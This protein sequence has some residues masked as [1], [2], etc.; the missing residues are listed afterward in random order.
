MRASKERLRLRVLA[1]ATLASL[2]VFVA[3]GFAASDRWASFDH[4][5][6]TG[7]GQAAMQ[8]VTLPA[9]P[10]RVVA[11]PG[12][13]SGEVWAIGHS[14]AVNPAWDR[15]SPGGQVIFL[16]YLRSTGWRSMGPP[17]DRNNNFTNPTLYSFDIAPSGEGWAVGANAAMFHKAPGSTRWVENTSAQAV[18]GDGGS[19]PAQLDSVSLVD[20]NGLKGFAVGTTGGNGPNRGTTILHLDSGRWTRESPSADMVVD[21]VPELISVSMVSASEAWAISG[22]GSAD[23]RVYHLQGTAWSRVDPDSN[24]QY[25]V[26]GGPHTPFAQMS[27]GG[28]NAAAFGG[29]VKADHNG[30]W[31]GGQMFPSS[32]RNPQGDDTAGDRSRPFMLHFTP[33]EQV[34]SYCPDQYGADLQQDSVNST[35]ICERPFPLSLYDVTSIS[36]LPNGEAFA[37]GLGLYHFKDEG[38]FREPD[39]EGY[40]VSITFS[41]P[42]EGWVATTGNTFGAGGAVGSSENTLGHWTNQPT[43]PRV[44]EWPQPQDQPLQS[45]A[46]QPDGSGRA[47]AV[48]EIGTTM[49]YLPNVGWDTQSRTSLESLHCVA[50]AG[51]A[52]AWAV[53]DRGTLQIFKDGQWSA[54]PESENLTTVPLF[55]VAFAGP[56][57]GVAVGSNG[58][59]LRFNGTRWSRDPASSKVTTQRLLAVAANAGTMIAVGSR[60]AVI[61]RV[62]GTWRKLSSASAIL[63]NPRLGP[64][65]LNTVTILPDGTALIAGTRS[66]LIIRQP[67]RAFKVFDDQIQ[68]NILAI[69]GVRTHLGLRLFASV[70]PDSESDAAKYKGTRMFAT[71]SVLMSYDGQVWNDI[72]LSRARTTYISTDSSAYVD[73]MYGLSL[74]AD[75]SGWAVGGLAESQPDTEHPGKLS[76]TSSVY[77]FDLSSSPEPPFSKARVSIPARGVNLAFVA[78]TWCERGICSM[79]NGSGTQAEVVSR[80]I[81]DQV[82]EVAQLRNGP[83]FLLFGGNGRSIGIPEEVGQIKAYLNGFSI[84]AY[85]AVGDRDLSGG[86][87]DASTNDL[88]T[89]TESVTGAANQVSGGTVDK[90]PLGPGTGAW[91]LRFVDMH[92]PWGQGST[93]PGVTVID[94]AISADTQLARTHYAFD[95]KAPGNKPFRV[96]V[97]DSSTRSY[98]RQAGADQNPPNEDQRSWFPSVLGTAFLAGTPTIVVMNQPTILPDQT[99]QLNWTTSPDD[100]TNFDAVVSGN[101]VSAVLTGGPRWNMSQGIPADLPVVPLYIMG[102]GGAPLGYDKPSVTAQDPSKLPTDGFYNAWFLVNIDPAT[103]TAIGL[104]QVAVDVTPFPILS[105]VSIHAVDGRAAPAGNI[106]RFSGKAKGLTGGVSDPEQSKT[107]YFDLG[108]S[109]LNLCGGSG[110]GRGGCA[111]RGALTPPYRFWSEDPTIADFVES[112][113]GLGSKTPFRRS[114]KIVRDPLGHLGVLCTFRVGTTFI[115]VESGFKK[116]RMKI[117]VGGGFGPC[118]DKPQE[119]PPI[120]DPFAPPPPAPVVKPFFH[121]PILPE[122]AIAVIPP[123]LGPIPAPAPPASA[124]GARKEESEAQFEQEGQEEGDGEARALAPAPHQGIFDP[125]MGWSLMIASALMAFMGAVGVS[126]V[127]KRVQPTFVRVDRG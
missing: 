99:P 35:R 127:R 80:E 51:S 36:L 22:S 61:E 107:T 62:D 8:A 10:A 97:V 81:Q 118:V 90:L 44:A 102:G 47:L 41:S 86:V 49:G 31:V 91:K 20:D 37:G 124:A 50:W 76:P 92:A 11:I 54:P 123:A 87:K 115:N 3:A 59:I 103:P 53:G 5:D 23:L 122:G 32:A 15:S 56:S 60:G 71:R 2:L 117:D 12:S 105:F 93:P 63:S 116:A 33:S 120:P 83:R 95:Y 27:N 89:G 109:G 112:D 65:E 79:T 119:G 45:V 28:F 1:M 34:T 16:R 24:S 82:N 125:A 42:T 25:P 14:D 72:S 69:A 94:S 7:S 21:G 108:A 75:G 84:P 77:R 85:G 19:D 39:T 104:G 111:A 74:D 66:S 38:W 106:L 78:E 52:S 18:A 29:A 96:V 40:L 46:V 114:G 6:F 121:Q 13:P 43:K 64:P 126:T 98:G 67:G 73:P 48:G 68:G 55:G 58:T 100:K 4:S 57:D 30:A 26:F 113:P 17:V 88:L 101:A 9:R 70:D 110:Q